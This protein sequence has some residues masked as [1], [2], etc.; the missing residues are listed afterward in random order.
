MVVVSILP[1][2][3]KAMAEW[4]EIVALY[5]LKKKDNVC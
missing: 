4:K 1:L 5:K 3:P 2:L